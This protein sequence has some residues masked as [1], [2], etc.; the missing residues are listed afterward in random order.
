MSMHSGNSIAQNSPH[1]TRSRFLTI[2]SPL[3]PIR[4][5]LALQNTTIRPKAMSHLQIDNDVLTSR[6]SLALLLSRI[7]LW[8]ASSIRDE[9]LQ[10]V[11]TLLQITHQPGAIGL[12]LQCQ[13]GCIPHLALDSCSNLLRLHGFRR[14]WRCILA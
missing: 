13:S 4:F 7:A 14:E 12:L 9:V 3:A 11:V 2:C 10:K 1:A 6:G 8:T 5:S